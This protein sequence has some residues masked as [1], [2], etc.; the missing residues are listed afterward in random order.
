MLVD[1]YKD[2]VKSGGENVSSARVE[3]ALIQ[4]P[5]VARA[6]V[7]GIPHERWGEIVA[8]VVVP[9]TDAAARPTTS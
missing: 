5:A 1:R 9:R 7:I 4:H 6:A 8:A 2:I 3:G